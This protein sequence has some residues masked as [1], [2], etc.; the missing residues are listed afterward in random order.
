MR[1]IRIHDVDLVRSA[2][3]RSEHDPAAIGAKRGAQ[4]VPGAVRQARNVR[5]VRI[6]NVDL[7]RPVAIRFEHDPAW[8]KGSH[9]RD[10]D[11]C[12]NDGHYKRDD[13]PSKHHFVPPAQAAMYARMR[14]C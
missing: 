8:W 1:P 11:T 5:S 6:H 9:I 14:P 10:H 4:G 12:E 2:S 3:T 7:S 13:K